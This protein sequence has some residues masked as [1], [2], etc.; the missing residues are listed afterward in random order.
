[1]SERVQWDKRKGAKEMMFIVGEVRA[2]RGGV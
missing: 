2:S 1:V